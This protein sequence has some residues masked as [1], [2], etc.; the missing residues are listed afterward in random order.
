MTITNE[1]MKDLTKQL[2]K[3]AND[4]AY[5]TLS[6]LQI[7]YVSLQQAFDM[8]DTITAQTVERT[9]E[10]VVERLKG[11][12]PKL[13]NWGTVCKDNGSKC[14]PTIWASDVYEIMHSIHTELLGNKKDL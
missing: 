2:Q 9:V 12:I 13:E 10:A 1:S 7:G 8:I 3:E 5:T 11:E 6:E 14:S 4:S